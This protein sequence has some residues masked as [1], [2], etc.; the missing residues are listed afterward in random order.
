MYRVLWQPYI[1]D[2]LALRPD[3]CLVDQD[4]WQTMSPLIFFY[5]VEWHC[6]KRVL[7]QFGVMQGIPPTFSLDIDLH[8]IDQRN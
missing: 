6:P 4:I 7:Q 1:D 3:I 8:S 2:I 5:I